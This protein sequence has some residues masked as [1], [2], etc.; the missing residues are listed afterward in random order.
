MRE[1]VNNSTSNK[2]RTGRALEDTEHLDMFIRGRGLGAEAQ[3]G[4][5]AL[6]KGKSDLPSRRGRQA[7]MGIL[8]E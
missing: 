1:K 2:K 7:G 5:Q 8:K 6:E 4:E 3:I